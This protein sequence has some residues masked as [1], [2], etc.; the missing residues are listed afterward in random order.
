MLRLYR[1]RGPLA[2]ALKTPIYSDGR[3][4][5]SPAAAQPPRSPDAIYSAFSSILAPSSEPPPAHWAF[6]W[7]KE[8]RGSP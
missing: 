1:R 6:T 2:I 7:R 8:K 5:L 3:E 4:Y